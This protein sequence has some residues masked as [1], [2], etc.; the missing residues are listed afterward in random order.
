MRDK[1]YR[2][3]LKDHISRSGT[4][5]PLHVKSGELSGENFE[6]VKGPQPQ[7]DRH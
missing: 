6:A 1:T 2:Q 3:W 7:S 5:R 4:V